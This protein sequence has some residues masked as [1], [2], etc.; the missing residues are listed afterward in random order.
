M[1]QQRE[2]YKCAKCGNIVEVLHGA[3]GKLNCCGEE[4]AL[5]KE[6]TVDLLLLD[7]IMDPG[8]NGRET[9]DRAIKIHPN[10]K[11]VIISGFTETDDVK[12]AQKLGAGQYVKKPTTLEKIGLA[13]KKELEK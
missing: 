4:M 10:Q 1:A 8:I 11:A 12:E 13:V 6:N 2:I 3:G 7:M 9:Y 5:L